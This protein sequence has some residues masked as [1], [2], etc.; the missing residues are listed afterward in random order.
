MVYEK[1]FEFLYI[2]PMLDF[3]FHLDFT[4]LIFIMTSLTAVSTK[5]MG[6]SITLGGVKK[7]KQEIEALGTS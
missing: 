2:I 3:F 7:I 4:N 5:P 1:R 6:Q